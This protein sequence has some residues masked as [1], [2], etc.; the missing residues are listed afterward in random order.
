MKVKTSYDKM[1]KEQSEKTS[2]RAD[3]DIF[4]TYILHCILIRTYKEFLHI[5]MEK[6]LGREK[7]GREN[8]QAIN[9]RTPNEQ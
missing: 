2:H 6:K 8:E 5:Y 9:I 7:M 3:G 1:H 4:H